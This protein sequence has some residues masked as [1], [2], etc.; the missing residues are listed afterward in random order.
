[1]SQLTVAIFAVGVLDL[2]ADALAAQEV[3]FEIVVINGVLHALAFDLDDAVAHSRT[4][5]LCERPSFHMSATKAP[6]R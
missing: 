3:G 6:P 5:A 2:E 1:M 4:P